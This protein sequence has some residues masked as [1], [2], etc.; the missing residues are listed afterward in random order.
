MVALRVQTIAS[1]PSVARAAAAIVANAP[2]EIDTVLGWI[3]GGQQDGAGA[4]RDPSR[5]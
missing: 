2:P 5:S 3:D 4:M 1:R